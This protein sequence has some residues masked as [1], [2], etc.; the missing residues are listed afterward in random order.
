MA[1]FVRRTNWTYDQPLFRSAT[2]DEERLEA[3][4][5]AIALENED[6]WVIESNEQPVA[7]AWVVI[8]QE[9]LRLR[10]LYVAPGQQAPELLQPLFA[11]IDTHYA[12]RRMLKKCS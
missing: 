4:L 1:V 11:Q 12:P 5:A 10:Q 6:L 2:N 8:G 3:M 9:A 7:F